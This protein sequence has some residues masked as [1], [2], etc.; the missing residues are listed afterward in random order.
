MFTDE[1]MIMVQAD[2]LEQT[3]NLMHEINMAARDEKLVY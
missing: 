2:L 1:H 3:Y